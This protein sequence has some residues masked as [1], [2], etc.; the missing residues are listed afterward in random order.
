[1][2]M[3]DEVVLFKNQGRGLC[4]WILVYRRGGKQNR[5][6]LTLWLTKSYPGDRIYTISQIMAIKNCKKTKHRHFHCTDTH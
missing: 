1:M 6:A 3:L 4:Y 5:S 2:A